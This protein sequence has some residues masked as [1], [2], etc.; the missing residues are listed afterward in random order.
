MTV[1]QLDPLIPVHTPRGTGYAFLAI[2]YSQE[3]YLHFAVALDLNGEIHI[4]DNRE[5][6]FLWNR[7]MGR[8]PP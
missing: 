7:T 2:D 5:V 3:H 4:F 6:R 8:L 1:T